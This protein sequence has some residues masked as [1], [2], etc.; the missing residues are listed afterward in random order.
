MKQT[1]IIIIFIFIILILIYIFNKKRKI[2]NI[3]SDII[4]DGYIIE[5]NIF[6]KE[7]TNLIQQLW[8]HKKFEDINVL[9]QN[10]QRLNNFIH[11]S[12]NNDY[13]LQDYIMFIENSVL[14]SCHSDSNGSKFNKDTHES[15][16]IIIYIDNMKNCL[17]IAPKSHKKNAQQIY[18]TGDPTRTFICSS[19]DL[20]LFNSNSLHAGSVNS[21][22][23]NRRIQ[24]KVIH[25]NDVEKLD[26]Y[27]GYHKIINKSNTNSDYSKYLQKHLTCQFP[28]SGNI[29]LKN[30]KEYI[31]GDINFLTKLYSYWFYGD[32]KYYEIPD[33]F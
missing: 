19:G 20:I 14:H 6:S 5:N 33:A 31:N 18:L 2:L 21:D 30:N 3:N 7:K 32:S 29:S 27:N 26:Y 12:L 28:I 22:K 8:D 9:I 15:Y 23:E 25:K 24:L 4:D 13:D 1:F 11:N 10:D 17:D 16:T